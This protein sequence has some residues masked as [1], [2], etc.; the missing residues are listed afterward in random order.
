MLSVMNI[1][2]TKVVKNTLRF[3]LLVHPVFRSTV[4]GALPGCKEDN[5]RSQAPGEFTG[6][7]GCDQGSDDGEVGEAEGL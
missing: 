4:S 6:T 7:I 1:S 3:V 5:L 2:E